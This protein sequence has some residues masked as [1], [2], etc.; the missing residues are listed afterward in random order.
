MHTRPRRLALA[1]A[2]AAAAW[3]LPAHDAHAQSCCSISNQSE[4]KSMFYRGK[5]VEYFV[6]D[7][8]AISGDIALG[9][10]DELLEKSRKFVQKGL[11]EED[12]GVRWPGGVIPYTFTGLSAVREQQVRFAMDQWEA[13]TPITFVPRTNEQDYV[14][15][16]DFVPNC[17]SLIGRG[18]NGQPLDV[19]STSSGCDAHELGHAIGLHHEQS[20]PDRDDFVTINWPNVQCLTEFN[21]DIQVGDGPVGDYD[22][23]S[24]MHYGAFAFSCNGQPTI[25]TIP[26]GIPI[27]QRN[28]ISVGDAQ[29]VNSIYG[30][31]IDLDGDDYGNPGSGL[32]LGTLDDCDDTNP[33]INPGVSEVPGNGIDDNCNGQIDEDVPP[34]ACP[35]ARTVAAPSTASAWTFGL[36]V[37]GLA[38]ATRRRRS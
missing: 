7:G 2:L 28:E 4:T 23:G 38:L 24:I 33:A 27:G 22:Y 37:A 10:E 17:F 21:F 19:S 25:T 20:R 9:R 8:W 32:C 5:P 31:C 16:G 18:G 30:P 13:V 26:P 11:V 1:V 29:A 34:P 12:D 36:I 35:P 14:I 15:I 3:L 6:W